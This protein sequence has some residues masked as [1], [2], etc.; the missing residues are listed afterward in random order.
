[1]SIYNQE[2]SETLFEMS[3]DFCQFTQIN[4]GHGGGGVT[5]PTSTPV[6]RSL[7][8]SKSLPRSPAKYIF[9][10]A[11]WFRNVIIIKGE[12]IAVHFFRS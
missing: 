6:A 7:F 5:P 10:Y 4:A 9:S 8:I 11:N 3:H 1:M 2:R 12:N